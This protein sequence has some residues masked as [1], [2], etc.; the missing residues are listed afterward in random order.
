MGTTMKSAARVTV[1]VVALGLVAG[2][3]GPASANSDS[4][5]RSIPGGTISTYVYIDSWAG[6]DNCGSFKTYAKTSKKVAALTHSV[7]WDPIGIGASAQIKG[8]GVTVSGNS[9][10]SPTLS[11]TN[12]NSSYAGVSGTACMSWSTIYLGVFS[13]G[14]TK[15]NGVY[16]TSTSHV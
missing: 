8:V 4:D 3:A 10:G 16:Y 12:M 6:S 2:A 13:T 14:S 7:E 9:G 15:I 1:F 11:F 5:S